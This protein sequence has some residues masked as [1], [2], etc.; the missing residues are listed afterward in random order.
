MEVE[1]DLCSMA[2]KHQ[3]HIE[4]NEASLDESLD[5]KKVVDW[6]MMPLV[7]VPRLGPVDIRCRRKNR[8]DL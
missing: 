8:N 2:C 7:V 5:C 1:Q 3:A 4:D 6:E